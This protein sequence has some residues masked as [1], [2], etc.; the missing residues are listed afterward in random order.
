MDGIFM[1]QD[2]CILVV[3]QLNSEFALMYEYKVALKVKTKLSVK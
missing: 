3:L 1:R 2:W